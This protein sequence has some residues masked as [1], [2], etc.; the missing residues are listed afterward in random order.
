MNVPKTLAEGQAWDD[1]LHNKQRVI[2]SV[3]GARVHYKFEVRARD[4]VVDWHARSCWADS[5]WAW[6]RRN[7]A[8]V[9]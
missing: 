8:H 2:T 3:D 1:D 4:G 9:R 5:F 7:A 6:V